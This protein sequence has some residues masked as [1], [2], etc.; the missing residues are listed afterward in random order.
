MRSRVSSRNMNDLA[1]GAALFL[2]TGLAAGCSSG[3]FAFQRGRFV[4]NSVTTNN[5]QQVIRRVAAPTA[6]AVND[7]VAAP[8]SGGVTRSSLPPAGGAPAAAAV[9]N[10]PAAAPKIVRAP[11]PDPIQTSSPQRPKLTQ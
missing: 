1:R 3:V 8:S 2:I 10:A 11:A 4:T 5:Q 9:A 7:Y 6:P